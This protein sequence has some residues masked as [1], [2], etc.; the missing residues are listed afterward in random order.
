MIRYKIGDMGVVDDKACECGRAF[1]VIS[2]VYGRHDDMLITPDGRMIGR[3]DPVFKGIANTIKET[4]IIQEKVDLITILIVVTDLYKEKHGEFVV[5]ELRKRMGPDV[6]YEIDYVDAIPRTSSG[7]F[8]A[9]INK[10][11]HA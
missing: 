5:N 2:Q 11:P 6:T 3:L 1:P 4:Q 7:K 8:R 10:I 9:V